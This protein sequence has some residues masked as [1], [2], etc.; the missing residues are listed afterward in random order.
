MLFK[1]FL[2]LSRLNVNN[3]LFVFKVLTIPLLLV[4]VSGSRPR[5]VTAGSNKLVM[6]NIPGEATR[7]TQP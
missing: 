4:S 7:Q 1:V 2:L 6:S 5:N 3:S